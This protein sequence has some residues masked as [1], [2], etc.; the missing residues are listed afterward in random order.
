MR[1]Y[2]SYSIITEVSFDVNRIGLLDRGVIWASA[3]VRC[4]SAL[5][6]S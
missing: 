1:G 2:G 4:G 5:S 3:H 6:C